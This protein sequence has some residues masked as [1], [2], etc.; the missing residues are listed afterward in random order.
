[1]GDLGVYRHVV[2]AQIRSQTQYRASFAIEIIGSLVVSALD[3][4]AVF[5]LFSVSGS[6]GGFTGTEVLL[7]TAMSAF[8]FTL[9][10]M[11]FGNT[12][13]LREYVRT[14]QFDSILLRPLS[15]LGQLLAVNF[16]PRRIGRVVQTG[17]LYIVALFV[18]DIDWSVAK[19]AL[20]LIAPLS[21]GIFFGSLFVGG[22][23]VAFWWTETGEV[24]NAFTYGG[25]D[26]TAYPST[27]YGGWFREV[28]AI[29]L[30]FGFVAYLP[31]LALLGQSD[32]LGTPDWLR[33]CSPVPALVAAVLASMFW[34]VGI[35][36]YRSTGS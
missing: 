9:A 18:A 29:G 32:P 34:R 31:A 26:F 16:A 14:G 12:D 36:R 2:R 4:G 7:V 28:F 6:L 13:R 5:V 25:R 11:V 35:R 30:G 1:M 17:L 10:D 22:A 19:A 8:A 27:M 20:V 24:A 3:I 21:G 15:A 23:T 33:W